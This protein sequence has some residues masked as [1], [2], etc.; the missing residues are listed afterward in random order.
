MVT[1]GHSQCGGDSNAVQN[2]LTHVQA[3]TSVLNLSFLCLAVEVV[4]DFDCLVLLL[5]VFSGEH[6]VMQSGDLQIR[7]EIQSLLASIASGGLCH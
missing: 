5:T 2:H 6:Q 1:W 7:Q 3:A 4:E